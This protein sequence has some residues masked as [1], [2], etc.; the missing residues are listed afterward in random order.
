[1][2][3]GLGLVACGGD[4]D[5]AAPGTSALP[6]APAPA[7][8]AGAAQFNDA[9]IEFAQGMIAHHEQA[10]EMSEIALD[11]KV[12]AG[13]SVTDLATR[14]QAAQDPEIEQMTAWLDAW[15]QPVAMDT[16]D[17]HDM[18]SMEG[19]MSAEEMDALAAMTG[20]TFDTRWLE[21]MIEHHT[22]A[23]TMAEDVKAT[24]SNPEVRALADR[25]IATQQAEINEMNALLAA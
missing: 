3:A 9:D 13:A 24:G 6:A 16:S 18:A 14:I 20:E 15:G 1:M 21:M 4:D 19:M 23:I 12:G 22:G 10:I 2:F 7:A 25:I 8:P 17:G 5:A 11:P